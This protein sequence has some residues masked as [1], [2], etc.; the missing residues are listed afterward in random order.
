MPIGQ[1]I[2]ALRGDV[3]ERAIDTQSHIAVRMISGALTS[4]T[5]ASLFGGQISSQLARMAD[6]R[7]SQCRIVF[8]KETGH[9]C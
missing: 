5:L 3:D 1:T 8:C 2:T 6:G 9:T 4:V 7:S